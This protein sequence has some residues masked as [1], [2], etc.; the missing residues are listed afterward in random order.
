MESLIPFLS[1]KKGIYD[2]YCFHMARWKSVFH[3]AFS[4]GNEYLW[5]FWAGVVFALRRQS[6][7]E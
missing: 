5:M 2:Y 3:A 4:H 1:L 6:S 7:H